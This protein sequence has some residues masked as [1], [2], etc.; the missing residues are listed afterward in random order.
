MST[1]T[2]PSPSILQDVE[3][4]LEKFKNPQ[5]AVAMLSTLVAAFGSIGI[6]DAPLTGWLQG[7]LSAA[8]ALVAAL[9]AKPATAAVVRRAA[10]KV[11]AGK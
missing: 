4:F 8:L 3:A 5:T 9:L 10:R 6:L 7:V 11:A 2:P 1:P